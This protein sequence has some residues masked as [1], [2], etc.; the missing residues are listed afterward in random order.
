MYATH[1]QAYILRP[2]TLFYN[3]IVYIN[4]KTNYMFSSIIE[5]Q[6]ANFERVETVQQERED[7]SIIMQIINLSHGLKCNDDSKEI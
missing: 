5:R 1:L 4:I 6:R 7:G 3:N 2:K